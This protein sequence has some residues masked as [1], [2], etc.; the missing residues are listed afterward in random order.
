[1]FVMKKTY[2]KHLIYVLIKCDCIYSNMWLNAQFPLISC[3]KSAKWIFLIDTERFIFRTV[4][5]MDLRFNG[6]SMTC[7]IIALLCRNVVAKRLAVVIIVRTICPR[8]SGQSLTE[9]NVPCF[10]FCNVSQCQ[11]GRF[12]ST[13]NSN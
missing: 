3:A 10:H 9:I 13:V 12:D 8:L 5:T 6:W 7:H 4:D 11:L 1:M 2:L